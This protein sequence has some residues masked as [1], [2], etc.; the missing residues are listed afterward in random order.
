[1]DDFEN[2]SDI[3]FEGPKEIFIEVPCKPPSITSQ[4]KRKKVREIIKELIRKYDFTFT[5]DVKIEIDWF[6]DEQSRYE[7]DHTPDIDNTTKPILDALC[8]KDGI[9]ID[10]C[11]VQSV[12]SIWLD[13]YK[14]D[15]NFSIRIKPHFYWE[16]FIKNG[17]VFIEYSKGLC[18]PFNF[19]GVPNE[20]QL[21]VIDK[22]DEMISAR[23]KW[24][25]MGVDYYVASR[26]MPSQ[27]AFHISKIKDFQV[28]D[29]KSFR[30]SL[31]K[32]G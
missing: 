8:G 1:M 32:N 30:K 25:E 24:M 29:Y 28:E 27:R 2:L 15:E 3:E 10:D 5:G 14:R 19:N 11:Q 9:L 12:S 31:K 22:F 23:K 13:R 17:L 4:G 21:L 6:V 16:K 7:S 20:M 26:E 18:F